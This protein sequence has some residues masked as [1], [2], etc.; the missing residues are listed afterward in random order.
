MKIV[1]K[2]GVAVPLGALLVNKNSVIGEYPDIL[3][4]AKWAKSVSLKVIQLLPVNDTGTSSSPY[5]ALTAFA[6]HPLYISIEKLLEN[7][8]TMSKIVSKELKIMHSS[9]KREEGKRYDYAGILQAKIKILRLIYENSDAEKLEKEMKGWMDE[10]EW[11]IP[12]AVFKNLK[13]SYKQASWKEWK[14]KDTHLSALEIKRRWEAD[15]KENLFYA[16]CAYAAHEQFRQA[17]LKV[18]EAGVVLK[19][20]IPILVNEDSADAWLNTKIF[21]HTLRVGSPPEGEG[22]TGQSWGFPSYVWKEMKKNGYNWW[23]KRLHTASSYYDAY[24]LDHVLGFFRIWAVDERESN[25]YLGHVEPYYPLSR[26]ALY[27]K[28]F[29]DERIRWLSEPH[30]PTSL[31][32]DITWN[33]EE[34]TA[35]LSNFAI[36]INTEELWLFKEE[37][38]GDKDISEREI[39]GDAEKVR[40]MK[41]ALAA[42]WRDRAL[43][44]LEKDDFAFV[45]KYYE[46]TAWKSLSNEEKRALLSL[47]KE[48]EEKENSIWEKESSEILGE[49]TG[50]TSMQACGED[51]GAEVECLARVLKENGIFA[52]RVI[53]WARKWKE[54][55]HPFI[56]LSELPEGAVATSSVH[57]SSTL[58]LWWQEEKEARSLFVRTFPKYFTENAEDKSKIE[59]AANED[60]SEEK[61]FAFLKTVSE[62]K[63]AW[64][65]HPIADYLALDEQYKAENPEDERINIPGTVSDFNWTYTMAADLKDLKANKKI[66]QRI[67]EIADIHERRK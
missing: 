9:F 16:W 13:A 2:T 12:Y 1:K 60:F 48:I 67:K 66:A 54:E 45:W 15:K 6:L 56:P 38:K 58:R 37:I 47:K 14:K 25:A 11:V 63:C 57:D 44:K 62:A 65:I 5:N 7:S 42:K 49:L 36:K 51:L 35:F 4:F 22:D 26:E 53:R 24:R 18:R 55:G 34:A 27:E 20:D 41:G 39:E 33:Y 32:Q 59:W 61:A 28:H 40:R 3:P 30:I 46:S 10:N 43:I 23:K 31:I 21:N 64:C 52:L 8:E 17:A 29:S 19:G 50:C